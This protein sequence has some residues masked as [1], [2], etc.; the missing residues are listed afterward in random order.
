MITTLHKQQSKTRL[1]HRQMC[2]VCCSCSFDE[3]ILWDHSLDSPSQATSGS[4]QMSSW[5]TGHVDPEK[6]DKRQKQKACHLE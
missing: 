6:K 5:M 4:Y 3:P 1:T 2:K